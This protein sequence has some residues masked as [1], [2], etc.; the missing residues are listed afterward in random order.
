MEG[1]T[2]EFVNLEFLSLINVG[3]M[4]VSNLPKLGKLKKVMIE[5]ARYLH[6]LF[7]FIF[8]K[9]W[10]Q[11]RLKW[12][13][14]SSFLSA[15]VEWQQNQWQPRCFSRETSQPHTSKPEWQQIERHQH[16]G[17]IGMHRPHVYSPRVLL[18]CSLLACLRLTQSFLEFDKHFWYSK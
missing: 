10:M 7:Y 4:T 17:T 6:I 18:C 8:C 12:N 14:F 2:A 9:H 11:T 3:L 15:G 13:I 1:L 5:E 16:I